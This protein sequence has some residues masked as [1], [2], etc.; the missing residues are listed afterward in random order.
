MEIRSGTQFKN[1]TIRG[2]LTI[3]TVAVFTGMENRSSACLLDSNFNSYTGKIHPVKNAYDIQPD[4]LARMMWGCPN[5]FELITPS[6]PP[7]PRCNC[8]ADSISDAII[9][10]PHGVVS[11]WVICSECGSQTP[12]FRTKEEAENCWRRMM[13]VEEGK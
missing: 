10:R 7:L 11:F 2:I 6:P 4:E 13:E 12:S 5:W 3:Y 9:L 1:T 8:G